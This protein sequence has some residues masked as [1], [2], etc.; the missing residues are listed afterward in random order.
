MKFLGLLLLVAP[1]V[2]SLVQLRDTA[3]HDIA[4]QID[5]HLPSTNCQKFLLNLEV[6]IMTLKYFIL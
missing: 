5:E 1:L 4:I 3:Y 6:R 2:T